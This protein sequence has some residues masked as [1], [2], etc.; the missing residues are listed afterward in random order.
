MGIYRMTKAELIAKAE[1]DDAAIKR[2]AATLKD[3]VDLQAKVR[4]LRAKLA[5]EKAKP[6]RVEV[7]EVERRVV[8]RVAVPG[9]ERVVTKEVPTPCPEQAKEI[10]ALQSQLAKFANC[11]MTE[12][13]QWQKMRRVAR[14]SE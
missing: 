2:A 1:R 4:D 10:K 5:D 12:F 7:R 11:D 9:P 14:G 3:N 13:E 6:P 8:E